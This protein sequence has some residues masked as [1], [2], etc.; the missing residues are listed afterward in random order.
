[1][2]INMGKRGRPKG[3]KN[4]T[5][6]REVQVQRTKKERKSIVTTQTTETQIQQP[7][8][9]TQRKKELWFKFVSK[10]DTFIDSETHVTCGVIY[11]LNGNTL[12]QD[13]VETYK[14]ND[15]ETEIVKELFTYLSSIK[16]TMYSYNEY[17]SFVQEIDNLINKINNSSLIFRITKITDEDLDMGTTRIINYKYIVKLRNIDIDDN[18]N[19]NKKKVRTSTEE[20]KQ[21]RRGRP[22]KNNNNNEEVLV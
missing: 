13:I 12:F 2:I 18:E 21:G 10:Q 19:D 9:Q 20:K 4:K 5:R 14:L 7:Q 22:R 3:S 15:H 16:S 8:I 17:N 11:P 6:T 1:V